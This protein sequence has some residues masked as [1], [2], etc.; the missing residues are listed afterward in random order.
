M[1]IKGP[2]SKP[3]VA[4][5][6]EDFAEVK[7]KAPEVAEGC[8]ITEYRIEVRNRDKRAWNVAGM[9][10]DANFRV[11]QHMSEGNEYEFRVLAINK[12]GESEYSPSS[13]SVLAKTRFIKP[14]INRDL[15]DKERTAYAGQ[16][17]KIILEIQAAP[18]PSVNWSFPDGR[19][20]K[21]DSR[22]ST[23]IDEFGTSVLRINDISRND[24]GNFR[25]IVKNSQGYDEVEVRVDVLGTP[26][27]PMGPL[28]VSG[29]HPNGCKLCW[30]KPNDDGGSPITGYVIEKKELDRDVWVACG[31]V[32]GKAITAMK[33]LEF[34]VN[35]LLPYFVYMFRVAAV[36]A[37]GE[38][39]FL[40]SVMPTVAK[41]A[42][43]PPIQPDTPRI[44]DFDKTWV[45]LEWWA[46]SN[47]DIKHYIVEKR[48]TFMVPKD[49]EGEAPPTEEGAEPEADEEAKAQEQQ[50]AAV[51]AALGGG[52]VTAEPA[53]PVFTGEFI[54]YASK[55]MV[56]LVTDDATPEVTIK[57]L[58]ENN[59]YQFRV[60]AVNK[61]GPS[62]PSMETD[63]V[64]CKIQ[65]Q[66]PVVNRDSIKPVCVS[67]GQTI[68]LSAKCIGEPIPAKAFFYGKI[69]IKACPSVDVN[70]KEHSLKVTML[71]ARRDDT[72]VYTFRCEN[73]HGRD[74]A[75]V[76]VLVKDI[77]SKP[78]GPLKIDDIFG[79]GC[80]VEWGPPE[81]DGGTPITHYVVEKCGG[82]S[83]TWSPCGRANGDCFKCR[84]VGLTPDK[85]YRMQVS[86]VNAEG[87]S[88]P[89]GGV[90]TFITEN[91]FGTP[92]APG[93][94]LNVG[95][96][97]DHFDLKWDAPKNDGGSKIIGYQ[98]EA[99]PWKDNVYFLAGEQR[100]N[101]EFGE[102]GGVEV[103]Q[104]Y[105]VR[106]RAVN[107][108]GPGPWSLDSDQM[109]ARYKA[110]KPKIVFNKTEKE[111]TF[112]VGDTMSFSV[113][114]IGE[115]ACENITW[116]LGDKELVEGQGNG[117]VIDNS[118]PY[119]SKLTLEGLTR[120]DGGVLSITASNTSGKSWIKYKS[121][122]PKSLIEKI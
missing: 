40:Q 121:H 58:G 34:D 69:E 108:A 3:E 28:E 95:G 63:E 14:K 68:V 79:E 104:A 66:R 93:R 43:D 45:K 31:K 88:E 106:I 90:D 64:V 101:L 18:T 60:K 113:D 105:A 86:A 51:K 119:K 67:A 44:V 20:A 78:R 17:L 48:E 85:E 112:K 82:S 107:A 116:A 50:S 36:N 100:H 52:A 99:R 13:A 76:E 22:C 118:K 77:P 62:E 9:S 57:D 38:G 110:L 39:D 75:D 81:D 41:H 47:S 6:G 98:I 11:A 91:P 15:L 56:A 103:G 94:P 72:G 117:V 73:E 27:K 87:T 122:T 19:E 33:F 115:P 21:D 109:V 4:D 7:W 111:F 59:K 92:G 71:G 25:V 49:V 42:V 35:D 32:T 120:K 10:K 74:Q 70:E 30:M 114:V 55:W 23:E 2:P 96:D 8:E 54:E 46:P 26:V 37:Q 12:G 89:L 97:Y 29:V 102:A 80:T 1:F 16:Q 65:K 83:T 84:V 61:A 24:A 5:W 53:Q